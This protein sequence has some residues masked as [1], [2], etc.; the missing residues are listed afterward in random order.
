MGHARANLGAG[1]RGGGPGPVGPPLDPPLL[2]ILHQWLNSHAKVS[3]GNC[4]VRTELCMLNT[5]M[6]VL[7]VSA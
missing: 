3:E 6:S 1:A 7:S 2:G 4:G 5:C